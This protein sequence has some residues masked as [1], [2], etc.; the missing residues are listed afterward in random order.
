MEYE[1]FLKYGALGCAILVLVLAL[2]LLAK[3]LETHNTHVDRF[4]EI[5]EKNATANTELAGQV[6]RLV[7]LVHTKLSASRG[8]RGEERL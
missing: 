2:G 1:I 4:I 7:T 3:V 8:D 6:K 5:V